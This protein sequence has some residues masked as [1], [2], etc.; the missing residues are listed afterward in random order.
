MRSVDFGNIYLMDQAATL[1]GLK[2]VLADCFPHHWKEILTCAMHCCSENEALY[3]CESWAYNSMVPAAP[4]SQQISKLLKILDEDSR[5]R[6]YREWAKLRQEKEYLALDISSVSSWS[7][8]INYVEYGYNRDHEQLPQVN[9]AMLFGESSRLPVF[10]RIYPGSIKDVNTLIGMSCFMEQLHLKQMHFVMD[11]GGYSA[12]GVNL[13][14]EKY[15][16]FAIGVPFQHKN[17]KGCHQ[18]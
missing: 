18:G 15:I 16:K 6:F 13:M 1:C 2:K 4:S 10:A 7:E 3:L 14:L 9:L 5:M 17:G 12:K 11:K 8:L